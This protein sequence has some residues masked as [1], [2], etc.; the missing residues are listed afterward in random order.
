LSRIGLTDLIDPSPLHEFLDETYTRSWAHF[1]GPRARFHELVDW[2]VVNNILSTHR[3]E[4]PR[5]RLLKQ[6]QLVPIRNYTKTIELRDRE[7]YR[8]ISPD[9]FLRELRGG[10]TLA[11]ERLDHAHHPLRRFAQGLETELRASVFVNA[12]ASWR[13]LPGFDLHWDTQDVFVLQIAGRKHW[14]IFEPTRPW[15]LLHDVA[16]TAPPDESPVAEFDITQGDVLYVPHGWWHSVSTV[17]DE[18]SLHLAVGVTAPNGIDFIT[19]MLNQARAFDIFRAPIPV[20]GSDEDKRTHLD[21]L[22]SQWNELIRSG[23]VLQ[24]FLAGT[25]NESEY[26]PL[27]GLPEILD[28]NHLLDTPDARITLL[29]SRVTVEPASE[30]FILTALGRRWAFPTVIKPLLD[31]LLTAT[32]VTVREALATVTDVSDRQAADAIFKLIRAGVV[33]LH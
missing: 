31:A 21:A 22:K 32:P 25:V 33:A 14:K 8:Q 6:G 30:G 11:I 3:L 23:D 10:A 29:P 18:P 24:R 28:E 19:Q 7:P 17:D 12:V 4:T 27:F 16:E 5:V 9:S 13:A 15:P 2:D 1:T 20:F 26:R